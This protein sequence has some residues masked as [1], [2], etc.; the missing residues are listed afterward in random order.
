MRYKGG[1]HAGACTFFIPTLPRDIAPDSSPGSTGRM[2]SYADL[3]VEEVRGK[4]AQH[5]VQSGH[6]LAEVGPT[7]IGADIRGVHN[8]HML[9]KIRPK[10]SKIIQNIIFGHFV[11]I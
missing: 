11:N 2:L 7:G 4:G 5:N 6:G 1:Q 3:W 10:V 9:V 8:V